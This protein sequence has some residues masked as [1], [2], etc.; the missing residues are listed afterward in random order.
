MT[1]SLRLWTNPRIAQL[2]YSIP[3]KRLLLKIAGAAAR[4]ELSL[5]GCQSFQRRWYADQVD[6]LKLLG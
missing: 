2:L 5:S 6:F 1:A 3:L 4:V